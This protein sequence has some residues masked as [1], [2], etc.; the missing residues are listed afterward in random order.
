MVVEEDLTVVRRTWAPPD[1]RRVTWTAWNR[2]P[3]TTAR[4][5]DRA[6]P[7]GTSISNRRRLRSCP[8]S[9]PRTRPLSSSSR[10][11]LRSRCANDE[12]CS[13]SGAVRRQPITTTWSPTPSTGAP[14]AVDIWT[15][16]RGRGHPSRLTLAPA[17]ISI[18]STIP[19]VSARSAPRSPASRGRRCWPN[20]CSSNSGSELAARPAG[21][22]SGSLGLGA[23]D[24]RL[25][26]RVVVG[27]TDRSDRARRRGDTVSVWVL[28]NIY[29]SAHRWMDDLRGQIVC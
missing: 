22:G 21:R 11:S 20:T 28:I 29:V 14:A 8:P 17:R 24:E 3:L 7:R 26:G 9:S 2:M 1:V 5:Q 12:P 15:I 18:R 27:V 6:Q 10:A 16:D 4:G 23:V 19:L 25:G 13:C